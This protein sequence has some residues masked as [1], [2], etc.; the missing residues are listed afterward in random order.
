MT[1]EELEIIVSANI[2]PALKEIKKLMPEIKQQVTRAVNLAQKSMSQINMKSATSKVQKA[3]DSIEKK[4]LSLKN[5]KDTKMQIEIN[6]K[7]AQ[8]QIT[9]LE[10]E[11]DSLQKKIT[12]SKLKLN[13][14]TPRLDEIYNKTAKEVTPDGIS[15]EHPAIQNTINNNLS[16]N[17]EY[18]SLS[19]QEGKLVDNIRLY[20]QQLNEAK[21]KLNQLK[22]TINSASTS[23]SK[24]ASFFGAFKGKVDQASPAIGRIK[25]SLSQMPKIT[26]KVTNNIKNMGSSLKTGL[27]HILK[28]SMALFSL[29]GIYS[30]L[31]NSAR[32][33]LSSQNAGAQQ[34]SANI[35]Y[36]KYS[37]G[38]VFAPIIE[39]V[40]NLVYKL[41]KAIQSV[42][43]AFRG[44][45]IFAKATA[46]SMNKTA[47]SANKASK[48]LAGV[49]GE[50]NN[51][52]DNKDSG[53]VGSVNP[54][55]DLTK[56]DM[57][58]NAYMEKAKAK[59]Q[60]LFQ[61]IQDSWNTYGQPLIDSIKNGF[62]GVKG[63][64]SSIKDSF[65]E[66][67]LNGTGAETIN[68]LL[69]G[70]TAVFNI[71]GNIGQ[72]FS[73]AW[74]NGDT[75][76]TVV[77][78]IWNAFNN[79]YYI[80]IGIYQAFEEWTASESFQ[81]FANSIMSI[82][83]TL[84]GWFEKIT[85][86]LKEIWDNGGKETFTKLL[87]FITKVIE[88]ISVIL[89]TLDP[90]IQWI[91]DTVTPI[92]SDIV[93]AIG[94]VIDALSGVLD[95]IIG[96]FTGDWNKAWQGIKDFFSGIWNAI[97][98][99]VSTVFNAIK[100]IIS[101]VL[102]AIKKVWDKIWNGIKTV[103][104]NIWNGI[105]SSIK[106]VINSILKGIE[107]FVNGV[108]KGINFVL[109][110]ISKVANAVGSL[111]GL[112]PINLKLSTISL[113]R[114]AKGN[115]AYSETVAVFGEY[116]GARNNPEITTPQ[117]VMRETFIDALSDYQYSNSSSQPIRV[118]IYWGTK[119]VVDEIIDGINEK[120]RQTGKAQIRVGYA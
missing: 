44:I 26:Q 33:W 70:W 87:E 6:N 71:I 27:K 63:L 7:Q 10:K 106:K 45:N 29:R 93:E 3:V 119:N 92:I 14:V 101:S 40:I 2:E 69:Q 65:K 15:S 37:M 95:F 117:N 9:Q 86:K 62:N 56:M 47:G 61:P 17:K 59:L 8:K 118:Q 120:T 57:S 74:N 50:I 66:V 4:L 82:C 48:S 72:A 12:A 25:N 11:I 31:S 41:M 49:H 115:V 64:I 80:V 88:T 85:Q 89:D 96:V 83:K 107:S 36:L 24:L 53:G 16:R 38:S 84:S 98:S 51:V 32:S 94:F 23:Q 114:L 42:V 75:G 34:L 18:Q 91:L 68:L 99:V 105:W 111:I 79:L 13:V 20:N 43:Y 77:Q 52:S 113:P 112:S 73:N 58:L 109:N 102:N 110:G 54:S 97:K 60:Q 30:V 108:I 67:W 78:N 21:T 116:S 76:T 46:S 90:V 5:N 28:Y 22:E 81:T 104:T 55:M 1:I 103:V 19:N 39:A 35:E 100:T